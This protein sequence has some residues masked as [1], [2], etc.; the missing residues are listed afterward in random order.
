MPK[1]PRVAIVASWISGV[2]G[3]EVVLH[4]LHKALPDAPIYTSTYEPGGSSLFKSATI[5]TSWMQKLPK[6]IRKHQLLT[7]PR[8]WYFG[9]LKL[10]NYDIVISA[11]STEE[12]A[13]RAP[14]GSS[15][16]ET[17]GSRIPPS[18]Y[19]YRTRRNKRWS[20]V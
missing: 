16:P 6:I 19:R 4:Q 8:Q 18:K 5:K 14:D 2:G 9:R 7:I 10:N 12:K 15:L 13:V 17:T 20:V 3:A 1:K 11:G